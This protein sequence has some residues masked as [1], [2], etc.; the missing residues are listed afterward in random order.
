MV[1]DCCL[2]LVL[3]FS[4]SYVHAAKHHDVD[5][6]RAHLFLVFFFLFVMLESLHL[7]YLLDVPYQRAH[8]GLQLCTVLPI[9]SV[10]GSGR[11]LSLAVCFLMSLNGF[12][13]LPLGI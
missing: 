13:V 7:Q 12:F 10:Q 1:V 4:G 2:H 8:V 5:S 11:C 9:R 3:V 6:R